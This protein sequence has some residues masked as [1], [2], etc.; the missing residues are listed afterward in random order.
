[1]FVPKLVRTI[2]Q[3][4]YLFRQPRAR[5]VGEGQ[6]MGLLLLLGGGSLIFS[7]VLSY[8]AARGESFSVNEWIVF[9]LSAA[10]LHGLAAWG[11]WGWARRS[12]RARRYGDVEVTQ[13]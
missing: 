13:K 5:K 10:V 1:M 8:S 9:F 3:C 11:A 12:L 4:L 7:S 6:A 2:T